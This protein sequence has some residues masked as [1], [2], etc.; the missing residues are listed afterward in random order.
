MQKINSAA[1]LKN[2]ILELEEKQVKESKMMKMQCLNALERAKPLN[3]IVNT[4]QDITHSLTQSKV[5]K[6]SILSTTLGVAAGYLSKGFVENGSESPFKKI[7]G[8]ALMFG[9]TNVVAQHHDTVRAFGS[10][11]M[12]IIEQHSNEYLE[13]DEYVKEDEY[14]ME[15]SNT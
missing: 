14:E 10:E 13:E 3:L 5:L 9:I 11:L 1:S 7:L 6:D 8:R 15:Y 12:K 2:A 4:F